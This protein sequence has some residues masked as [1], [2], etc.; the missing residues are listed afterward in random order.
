MMTNPPTPPLVAVDLR[1]YEIDPSELLEQVRQ[2][3]LLL[4]DVRE[5]HEIEQGFIAGAYLSPLSK[6]Q[7][8]LQLG[9]NPI[10]CLQLL[11]SIHS[12]SHLAKKQMKS[13]ATPFLLYCNSGARVLKAAEILTPYLTSCYPIKWGYRDLLAFGLKSFQL[14]EL[15]R[16][17]DLWL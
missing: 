3:S 7:S 4:V 16:N 14:P 10:E 13:L 2:R 6:L 9:V 1:Y 8:Y 17:A 11:P 5:M 15:D 12:R